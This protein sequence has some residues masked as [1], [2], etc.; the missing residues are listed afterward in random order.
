MARDTLERALGA[1]SP[2][3]R[4]TAVRAVVRLREARLSGALGAR[5]G[6][7]DEE[8]AALAA[9]AL[10]TPVEGRRKAL[11]RART[12]DRAEARAAAVKAMGGEWAV[13]A[14]GDRD[15]R[16]REAAVAALRGSEAVIALLL[17]RAER[18]ESVEV[19]AAALAVLGKEGLAVARAVIG[20]E[21]LAMRL[22][23]VGVLGRA[24]AQEDLERA[25]EGA[26]GFVALRAG[27]ILANRGVGG[28]GRRAVEL[29]LRSEDWTLRSAALNAV[30]EI[31]PEAEAQKLVE[32]LLDDADPR[33]KLAA[34]RA[35]ARLGRRE[36]AVAALAKAL[37]LGGEHRLEAAIDLDRLGDPRGL[38]HLAELAADPDAR[39]RRRA[40]A[41]AP[42][43]ARSLMALLDGLADMDGPAR[44][45][46]AARLLDVL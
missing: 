13:A 37:D 34:A 21:S 14:L 22:A 24:G 35:V 8:I 41:A 36:A 3:V 1:E 39:L 45:A 42:D 11:E 38:D 31:L 9:G 43:Y 18:D 26:D 10:A 5:L 20:H 33:V 25:A 6:D 15:A 16:V 2:E 29:A 23:A 17:E 7:R 32:P 30:A 27:V 28:R 40:L 4:E 19:R 44:V 46:A 12:S